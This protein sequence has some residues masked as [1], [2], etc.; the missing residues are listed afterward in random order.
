MER[1][2]QFGEPARSPSLSGAGWESHRWSIDCGGRTSKSTE[3][4][5]LLLLLPLL[6]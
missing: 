5:L 2:T 3:H 6:R 1:G 4:L